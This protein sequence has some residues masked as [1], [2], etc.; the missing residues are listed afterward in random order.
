MAMEK[1]DINLGS[2]QYNTNIY[3]R[4][5]ITRGMNAPSFPEWNRPSQ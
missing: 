5:N 1:Q 4:G 3:G 2:K